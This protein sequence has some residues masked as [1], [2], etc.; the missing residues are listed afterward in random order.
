MGSALLNTTIDP[1]FAAQPGSVP[2]AGADALRTQV[3]ARLAEHRNRRA[4]HPPQQRQPEPNRPA[5]TRSARIA[6]AVAE[7]YAQTPSY[8]AVLAAEAERAVQQARAA[9]EVAALNA[10]AVEAAQQRLLESLDDSAPP[11]AAPP[12]PA[13]QSQPFLPEAGSIP[14][15]APQPKEQDLCPDLAAE[16]APEA[17]T[18][19]H[20][21]RPPARTAETPASGFTVR[22]Y[23]DE[24]SAAHVELELARHAAAL[25]QSGRRMPG[26]AEPNDPEALALDDEI[27]FRHAPVFEEPAGPPVPL[28]ANLIEFPRHLVAPRKARP[29]YAEGP[30]REDEPAAP[31]DGQ[32]RIFEVDPAQ[33]STQP[34][35]EAESS[36]Q[37]PQWTS[38]WLDAPSAAAH[39]AAGQ[40]FVPDAPDFDLAAE[41]APPVIQVAP[42]RRRLLAA[43]TDCALAL[44]GLAAFAAGFAAVVDRAALQQLRHP[45][46]LHAAAASLLA[47]TG[48]PP[49]Q[50]AAVA[51]AAAVFLLAL[52]HGLFF[53]FSVAT[54]GM[55]GARIAL[56]TF[57]DENPT[58][59]AIRRRMAASL[60]S[61]GPLGLGF[62]WA[63]LDDDRLTWH[64]RLTRMYLRAY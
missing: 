6:A 47:H 12:Q 29:R 51:A 53:W 3:A 16:P 19:R 50:L 46:P 52:Y 21:R 41:P 9:A 7:R 23:E 25:A 5:N 36:T 20:P 18:P 24:A 58:R 57:D 35:A 37:A 22:L 54:P 31:L 64:D 27:A 26:D 13:A 1:E 8:R 43:A 32:L 17:H 11:I 34:A 39:S 4:G 63:A 55:R 62:A 33:I 28:P 44:T 2:S 59:R 60:L 56:C 15:P 10:Q 61:A 45:H 38:L 48:L 42:L 14:Q 30:L 40:P 49:M